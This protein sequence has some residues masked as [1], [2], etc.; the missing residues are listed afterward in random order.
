ME[1]GELEYLKL[2]VAAY[3]ATPR[4][5][6]FTTKQLIAETTNDL[7]IILDHFKVTVAKESE[8]SVF[9]DKM[10]P[11]LPIPKKLG[12]KEVLESQ[13]LL[14][15]DE[16]NKGYTITSKDTMPPIDVKPPTKES[17]E[18]ERKPKQR[19]KVK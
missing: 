3:F 15:K 12:P 10:Y 19:K 8:K 4:K 13:G 14:G 18:V 16:S 11:Q 17:V 6:V 5:G 2:F 9:V 1:I 7:A